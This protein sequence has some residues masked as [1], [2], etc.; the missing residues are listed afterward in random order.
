MSKH[1]HFK[2][3][4]CLFE[5]LDLSITCSLNNGRREL[6]KKKKTFRKKNL[7]LYRRAK[8]VLISIKSL[9]KLN[10]QPFLPKLLFYS[11]LA[12]K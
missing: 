7:F 6:F 8:M 2:K 3:L 10:D 4:L 1:W 9:K 12:K 11:T 5:W